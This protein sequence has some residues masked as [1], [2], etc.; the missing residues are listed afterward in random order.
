ML[1]HSYVSFHTVLC[2]FKV[3]SQ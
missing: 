1:L 3:R 2:H